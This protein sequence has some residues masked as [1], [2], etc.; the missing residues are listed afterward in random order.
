MI[1]AVHSNNEVKYDK[2]NQVTMHSCVLPSQQAWTSAHP[3]GHRT[4]ASRLQISSSLWW[5]V[6][7]EWP[8]KRDSAG[9]RDGAS[10]S[11]LRFEI[12]KDSKNTI[13][14]RNGN[15]ADTFFNMI[16]SGSTPPKL[17]V[18]TSVILYSCSI[19]MER[20]PSGRGSGVRLNTRTGLGWK[21]IGAYMLATLNRSFCSYTSSKSS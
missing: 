18:P 8:V 21:V 16:L 3:W 4:Y 5:G 6:P 20:P 9:Q 14:L 11:E 15:M 2:T 13:S 19:P 12:Q 17:P 10:G 1:R 7:W